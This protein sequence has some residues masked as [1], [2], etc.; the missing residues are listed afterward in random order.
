MTI[1]VVTV[2]ATVN[3][4]F[5]TDQIAELIAHLDSEEMAL[6]ISKLA[7]ECATYCIP[8][9]LEYLRQSSLLTAEGR[10]LMRLIGE[11]AEIDK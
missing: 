10:E 3:C 8:M 6:L 1:P 11:Y 7:E 4:Q 2:S 5:T 9:Q